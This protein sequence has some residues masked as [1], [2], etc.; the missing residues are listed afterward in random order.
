VLS[1]IA[2]E[3]V[4]EARHLTCGR[5][6]RRRV[7]AAPSSSPFRHSITPHL[8]VD[9]ETCPFCERDI[10]PELLEEISGKIA[11]REREQSQ[12]ITAKLEQ[13]FAAD[14]AQAEVL[15]QSWPTDP[16]GVRLPAAISAASV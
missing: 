16:S 5:I 10:P 8:H 11:A 13:Q 3:N 15:S 7:V 6:H 2:V 4:Q 14:K 12:A 9:N 1:V